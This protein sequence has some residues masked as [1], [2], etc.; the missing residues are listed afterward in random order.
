MK[1]AREHTKDQHNRDNDK[2]PWHAT[3]RRAV[4]ETD[5]GLIDGAFKTASMAELRRKLCNLPGM[6]GVT[7]FDLFLNACRA[8]NIVL[9]EDMLAKNPSSA[10]DIVRGRPVMFFEPGNLDA[11]L[12]LI[13]RGAMADEKAITPFVKAGCE[14]CVIRAYSEFGICKTTYGI[15]ECFQFRQ[16]H[17]VRPIVQ[18]MGITGNDHTVM[19]C[20]GTFDDYGERVYSSSSHKQTAMYE[21]TK[22]LY[23][24]GIVW[25][26]QLIRSQAMF[27][28]WHGTLAC[29]DQL[30]A[31]NCAKEK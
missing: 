11:F 15:L 19:Y 20:I 16:L 22:I 10:F 24:S 3:F 25:N 12:W 6:A 17:L 14:D 4:Y 13:K 7:D 28:G 31:K 18:R 8:C 30:E 29:L 9:M 21:A 26:S 23:G 5:T 27:Y 2:H 1:P